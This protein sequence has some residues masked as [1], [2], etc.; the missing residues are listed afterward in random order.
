MCVP[1]L[2]LNM[3]WHMNI[4]EYLL[5]SSACVGEGL[6]PGSIDL[7]DVSKS[8]Q[9]LVQSPVVGVRLWLCPDIS[10]LMP[11]SLIT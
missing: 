5:D 11:Q 2:F 4:W 10:N 1:A 3:H 7:G 8:L 9:V 6:K